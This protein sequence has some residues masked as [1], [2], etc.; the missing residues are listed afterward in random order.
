MNSK[1]LFTSV[2]RIRIPVL[3]ALAAGG[4]L[5]P[6]ARAQTSL[7][8]SG[9]TDGNWGTAANW[10][11]VTP[12]FG[13]TTD[14]TFNSNTNAS[15]ASP[16]FLGNPRTIRSL[17]FGANATSDIY[18]NLSTTVN[19]T[20]QFLTFGN[21]TSNLITVDPNSNANIFIGNNT[22]GVSM[23]GNLSVNHHGSGN[24]TFVRAIWGSFGITKNGTGTLTL[25][26][27]NTYAG[28]V[29]LSAGQL[30]I[31]HANALG[32]T[33]GT[34]TISGGTIDNTSAAAITNAGNNAISISANFAFGGTNDLNL[35]TGAVSGDLNRSITLN[36]S[37]KTLTLGGTWSNTANSAARTLT[38]NGAGNTLS[39]GGIALTPAAGVATT[40]TIAG[41]ANVNVTGNI[42]DGSGTAGSGLSIT[43]T[44]TVTLSGNNTYTGNTWINSGVTLIA[45]SLG[46]GSGSVLATVSSG[47]TTTLGLRSDGNAVFAKN[48]LGSSAQ[49][50]AGILNLNV[51]RATAGGASNGTI[52]LGTGGTL[53]FNSD[54][55]GLLFTGSN[56]YGL[57]LN[58][59]LTY[60]TGNNQG[61]KPN[62]TNNST[63]LVTILGNITTGNVNNIRFEM[64]G[65]GDTRVNGTMSGSAQWF[66]YKTG[67]GT[68]TLANAVTPG[69]T[70]GY[71]VQAGTL[72]LAVRSALWNA[73]TSSWTAAKIGVA[74]GATLAFNVGGANEFTTSDIT[75][76]L[77]NLAA[78]TAA[79]TAGTGSGMNAGSILGFDTTNASGGNFTITDTIADTTG[80]SGGARGLTKLG[81]GTLTLTGNNTYTGTTTLGAGTLIIN[82]NNTAANG[83]V[84]VAS[85]ATLGGNGRIGGAATVNGNLRP[86]FD[87]PGVLTFSSSL[88]L[89]STANLTMEIN[90]T[91]ARGTAYDGIDVTGAL[92]YGGNLELAIG[93]PFAA[94]NYTFNLFGFGSN[95]GTFASVS[96]SG[97]YSGSL[98]ESSGVWSLASEG[99]TW[100]FTQSTGVLAV[101]AVPE[102]STWALLGVCLG[103]FLVMRRRHC[104]PRLNLERHGQ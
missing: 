95:T 99:N 42:T 103:I 24:L 4:V 70:R 49:A 45:N 77:T 20:S 3:L 46:S 31:N 23:S 52:T 11:N 79:V 50:I 18:I 8:W 100:T 6:C 72:Q 44:G 56:G 90:G 73:T 104:R 51:D 78:S 9:T 63:G 101:S 53:S 43:N 96:L 28:G 41:T 97:A 59:S 48:I 2:L 88:T 35:G 27:N 62:I 81:T 87:G 26:G 5:A 30:N 65:T 16:S 84:S 17:N 71:A 33:A 61:N 83:A 32:A 15:L 47:N 75:T 86:G 102:P 36:G 39:L 66:L 85:G 58:Q 34:L 7:T 74:S 13:V 37:G 60:A 80:A 10:G 91:G 40:L 22:G 64:T 68:L 82:G 89:S 38:V 12:S 57:T 21:T 54:S 25:S 19:A 69:A 1:P 93:S 14:L 55:G 29:T 94:G 67:N 98:T 92:T 76:L